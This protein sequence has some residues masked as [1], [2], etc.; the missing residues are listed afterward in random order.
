MDISGGTVFCGSPNKDKLSIGAKQI[1]YK[2][3]DRQPYKYKVGLSEEQKNTRKDMQ[4]KKKKKEIS[5]MTQL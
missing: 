5:N 4:T 2:K 1:S 3:R